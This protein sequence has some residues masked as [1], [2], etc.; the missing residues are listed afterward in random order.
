MCKNT[1][2]GLVAQ[3]PDCPVIRKRKAF[4]NCQKMPYFIYFA[5]DTLYK[6]CHLVVCLLL[7]KFCV[8]QIAVW[9]VF[10][11]RT[12]FKMYKNAVKSPKFLPYFTVQWSLCL[13]PLFYTVHGCKFITPL[14]TLSKFKVREV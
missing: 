3:S 4:V 8:V 12:G 6:R 14:L 13:T 2:K 11:T 5:V 1:E 7:H 9:E 10:S